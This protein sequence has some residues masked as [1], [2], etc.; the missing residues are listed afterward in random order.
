[1]PTPERV[2]IIA[3][4]SYARSILDLGCGE[5]TYITYLRKKTELLV[6]V[7]K[8]RERCLKAHR[9]GYDIIQADA[10]TLPFTEGAF[11]T[12]WACEVIEHTATLS[13]FNEMERVTESE[14]IATMPNPHGPYYWMDSEHILRYNFRDLKG[15]LSSR[16]N[17]RYE[18]H[19]LGLTMPFKS[20]ASILIL[21]AR[22][23]YGFPRI[24]LTILIR[25]VRNRGM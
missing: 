19:G 23:T 10:S 2:G 8:S 3:S 25:G 1:M 22:L 11:N 21:I 6:G 14:I 5:G 20:I 7:D 9:L 4:L 13:V 15:F 18:I 12:T 24:A 16:K 17:W